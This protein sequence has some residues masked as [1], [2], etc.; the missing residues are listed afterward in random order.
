MAWFGF[1]TSTV[2]VIRPIY[3]DERGDLVADWD[4]AAEHAEPGWLVQPIDTSAQLGLRDA[5]IAR[6]RALA[7]ATADVAADDRIRHAG[8]VYEVDGGI[9]PWATPPGM[10][11][12][13][14]IILKRVEG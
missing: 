7:P 11:Q 5:V 3:V 9:E 8:V 6:W 10:L 2:D 12:H 4:N 14:E 1:D 13:V